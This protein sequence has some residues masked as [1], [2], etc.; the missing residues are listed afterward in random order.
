[1]PLA[2]TTLIGAGEVKSKAPL[3]KSTIV[4]AIGVLVGLAVIGVF[5]PQMLSSSRQAQ[6][7]ELAEKKEQSTVATGDTNTIDGELKSAKDRAAAEAAVAAVR[8]R[9]EE[10]DARRNTAA[11]Q[12]SPIPGGAPGSVIPPHA[13]RDS[14]SAV[15]YNRGSSAQGSA[16]RTQVANPED[17]ASARTSA[18]VKHDFGEVGAGAAKDPLSDVANRI[19]NMMPAANA[20]QV[21]GAPT[22]GGGQANLM[23]AVLEAQRRVGSVPTSGAAADQAWL[24]EYSSEVRQTKPIKSYVNTSPYILSQGKVIPAVLGRDLNS[25]L[26]GE[27]TACTTVD[28]YDS[29]RSQFLLMP[30]GSCLSGQYQSGVKV[31]QERLMFA[32]SRITMPNGV[33]F[34]LP[35]YSGSDLAGAA[36][37]TGDVNNHFFKMFSTSF[38]TAWLADRA[39]P[40]NTTGS[41]NTTVSPAGQVLVDVSKTILDRQRVIP[42]TI[43]IDKGTRI[44]VEVKQDMEF[45][46]PYKR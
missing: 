6:P 8:K 22:D 43:T 9:A 32:F 45:P 37:V 14:D 29:I 1:M 19:K 23:N 46:G 3:K 20:A 16:G 2:E 12:Q 13:R 24:K 18:S 4:W 27:V 17:D 31:G 34:D 38:M 10:E 25:D 5:A 33:S 26:P 15:L 11:G 36:G 35:G 39:T 28:I 7:A 30:K 44:N 21:A 42:P 40:T 41:G